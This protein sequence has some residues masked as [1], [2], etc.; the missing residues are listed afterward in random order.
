[1]ISTFICI[2]FIL[3]EALYC[4]EPSKCK[5][6][7]VVV[8]IFGWPYN[9]LILRFQA[10]FHSFQSNVKIKPSIFESI[11]ITSIDY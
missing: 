9:R 11:P 3:I 8:S 7:H 5:M 10:N 1:M 2:L 6:Q 4:N